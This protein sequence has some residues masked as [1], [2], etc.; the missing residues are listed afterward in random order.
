[1]K[2]GETRWVGNGMIVRDLQMILSSA[3]ATADALLGL[4][5]EIEAEGVWR[6]YVFADDP[7]RTPFNS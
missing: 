2:R 1:M 3:E 5:V 7:K 6:D 4:I